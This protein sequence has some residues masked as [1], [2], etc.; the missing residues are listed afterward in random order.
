MISFL[1]EI[2]TGIEQFELGNSSESKI[3]KRWKK[4][5]QVGEGLAK[6]SVPLIVNLA[7]QGF[8][9]LEPG[10]EKEIGKA[11]QGFAKDVIVKYEEDKRTIHSFKT[12]L[13][14]FIQSLKDN[15]NE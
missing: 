1:A 12:Q 10:W 11:V 2:G 7:T 15:K 13:G 14:E 5:K 9:K 8:L 3:K 4:A 6:G